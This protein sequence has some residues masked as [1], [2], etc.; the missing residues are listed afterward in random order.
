MSFDNQI[1]L[2]ILGAVILW[3]LLDLAMRENSY[4]ARR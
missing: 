1:R 4:G 3:I 2:F